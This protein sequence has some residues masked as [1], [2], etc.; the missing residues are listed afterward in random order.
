MVI[1]C[2]LRGLEQKKDPGNI[3]GTLP[4][5]HVVLR[6]EQKT[7]V[8]YATFKTG[9][10]CLSSTLANSSSFSRSLTDLIM[11]SGA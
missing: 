8:N 7:N 6:I 3:A 10:C 11:K 9:S 5:K 1:A 4:L 2:E